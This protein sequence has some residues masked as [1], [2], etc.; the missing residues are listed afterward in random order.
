MSIDWLNW[1]SRIYLSLFFI[2]LSQSASHQICKQK[3]RG[4]F[5]YCNV[6]TNATTQD[7][8]WNLFHFHSVL[9]TKH[10]F[11]QFYKREGASSFYQMI[12]VFWNLS[13]VG[14]GW[15]HLATLS[16][17]DLKK[18]NLKKKINGFFQN[19]HLSSSSFHQFSSLKSFIFLTF[20]IFDLINYINFLG[21]FHSS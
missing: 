6:P 20:V 2:S 7:P 1:I 4:V 13:S 15:N 3:L 8:A 14:L 16:V 17:I 12:L 10:V 21:I 19:F 11:S 18:F 9:I 5:C